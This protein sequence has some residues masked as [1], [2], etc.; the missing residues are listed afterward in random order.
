LERRYAA[1]GE[2]REKLSL[3]IGDTALPINACEFEGRTDHGIRTWIIEEF[4][5]SELDREAL[6][7]TVQDST[8]PALRSAVCLG[9]GQIP[10]TQI[11]TDERNRIAELAIAELDAVLKMELDDSMA[12]VRREVEDFRLF[13]LARLKRTEEAEAALAQWAASEPNPVYRDYV[14][15]LVQ[16]WLGRKEAA[17]KRAESADTSAEPYPSC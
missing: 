10:L 5:R 14:A 3:A 9:L 13:P 4:R 17:V 2:S 8:S 6:V 15:S 1:A 12:G 11:S 7:A 16:L